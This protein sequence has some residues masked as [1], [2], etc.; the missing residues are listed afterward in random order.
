MFEDARRAVG[1]SADWHPEDMAKQW[2][3]LDE[4]EFLGKYCLVVFES[5]FK[6]AVVG[7]HFKGI[8]EVFKDFNP[9]AVAR[10]KPVKAEKLPI[11]NKRKADGFLRGAKMVHREGWDRYKKRLEDAASP[12]EGMDML[13]ELPGIGPIT[14]KHL[15]MNIG[16]ADVAKDDVH[17][18]RCAEHCNA[19]VDELVA[20]LAEEFKMQRREVDAVLWKW[21]SDPRPF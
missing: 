8:S 7:K 5:G 12:R 11:A 18:Q 1:N 10:M 3:A 16:L 9:K 13:E 17:L 15:A 4:K 20:F 19:S 14:K 6:T 2:R 21:R